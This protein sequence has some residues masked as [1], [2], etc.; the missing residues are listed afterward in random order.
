MG[1]PIG[2]KPTGEWRNCRYVQAQVRQSCSR[3][4]SCV[5]LALNTEDFSIP[6]AIPTAPVRVNF[7]HV[8]SLPASF[9]YLPIA[10]FTTALLWPP[11][12]PKKP[13]S[14]TFIGRQQGK[15]D[16]HILEGRLDHQW[17][18]LRPRQQ[19]PLTTARWPFLA[20]VMRSSEPDVKS[21]MP[22]LPG[23]PAKVMLEARKNTRAWSQR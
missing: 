1:P 19:V 2:E 11:K 23:P 15:R 8:P 4:G 7:P 3:L 12:R 10:I 9:P 20:L 22:S 16:R 17:L 5:A 6:A 13:L 21:M 18:Y 14:P